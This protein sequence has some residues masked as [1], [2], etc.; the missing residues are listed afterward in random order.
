MRSC[1]FMRTPF[2]FFFW[3]WICDEISMQK[4][5]QRSFIEPGVMVS[6]RPAQDAF[7]PCAARSSL[8][9]DTWMSYSVITRFC[10]VALWCSKCYRIQDNTPILV[11]GVWGVTW[12]YTVRNTPIYWLKNCISSSVKAASALGLWTAATWAVMEP[13]LP[14]SIPGENR[15]WG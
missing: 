11:G 10:T 7:E 3:Y 15:G 1:F 14:S 9:V 12:E 6:N 4:T 2:F 13:V 8:G 5:G